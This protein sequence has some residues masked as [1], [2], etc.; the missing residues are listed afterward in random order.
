M[1]LLLKKLWKILE[2]KEN[3]NK[4]Y[5]VN[6]FFKRKEQYISLNKEKVKGDETPLLIKTIFAPWLKSYAVAKK[7]L[8]GG[9]GNEM[10]RSSFPGNQ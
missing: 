10:T 8:A 9:R 4:I 5:S 2:L 1:N 3:K 7:L 6:Y